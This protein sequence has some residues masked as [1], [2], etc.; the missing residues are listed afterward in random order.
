[1]SEE[2]P[3]IINDIFMEELLNLPEVKAMLEVMNRWRYEMVHYG[4]S[5]LVKPDIAPQDMW[6]H[7]IKS[8]P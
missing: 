2:L 5:E 3:E 4:Q 6:N 7:W 1:M 8:I